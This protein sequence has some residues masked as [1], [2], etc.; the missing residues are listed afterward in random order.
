MLM[1]LSIAVAAAGIFVSY[2]F[3]VK[4]YPVLPEKTVKTFKPIHKFLL[5]K[6]YFDELYDFLFVHPIVTI[7]NMLWRGFDANFIDFIVNAFGRVPM[8]LSGVVRHVQTGRLQTYIFTMAVGVI[9]L[10][11]IFYTV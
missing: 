4:M 3:Y 2:L 11:T 10:I 7:S 6:W 8:W 5:N 1:L 9:V